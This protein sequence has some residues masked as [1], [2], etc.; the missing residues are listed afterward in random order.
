M[1]FADQKGVWSSGSVSLVSP[2]VCPQAWTAVA[3]TCDG[4]QCWCGVVLS[5]PSRW[6]WDME[7][8]RHCSLAPLPSAAPKTWIS[9]DQ[10]MDSFPAHVDKQVLRGVLAMVQQSREVTRN[11]RRAWPCL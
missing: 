10:R 9:T 11:G 2:I 8:G 5:Q 3:V 7:P 6:K 1:G 4:E